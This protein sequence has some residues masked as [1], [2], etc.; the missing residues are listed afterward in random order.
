MYYASGTIVYSY[1]LIS[2]ENNEIIKNIPNY[3]DYNKSLIRINGDYLFVTIG[4][5]TNSG[6]VGLDNQWIR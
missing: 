3:G 1:N 2:K 4:A 5:A 6:V